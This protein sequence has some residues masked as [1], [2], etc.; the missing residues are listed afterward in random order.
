MKTAEE[1]HAQYPIGSQ[2]LLPVTIC[3]HATPDYPD[4]WDPRPIQIKPTTGKHYHRLWPHLDTLST[5]R[6]ADTAAT[7]LPINRLFQVGDIVTPCKA[8]DRWLSDLW[9]GREGM[10]FTV[11]KAESPHEAEMDVKDPDCPLPYTVNTAYF[12][13]ITPVEEL[14][15]YSIGKSDYNGFVNIEKKGKIISMIP[16]GK[17]LHEYKTEEEAKAAAE[18][19]CDRLNAQ[20]KIYQ[21]ANIKH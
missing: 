21:T 6:P 18:A 16:Y 14:E 20:H 12:T 17:E 1:Y 2:W 9:E 5:L 7:R 13:L 10:T 4:T 3:A 11:V 19:E 8:Q 15:P